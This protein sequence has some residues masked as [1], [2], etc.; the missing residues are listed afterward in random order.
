[1]TI[2]AWIR[3]RLGRDG[4][5][6]WSK[7]VGDGWQVELVDPFLEVADRCDEIR[8]GQIKEKFGTLRIYISGPKWAQDL[9]DALEI[10]SASYCED[11]G[12]KDGW[13]TADDSEAAKVTNAPV[14][15]WW[16]TLCQHCRAS[17]EESK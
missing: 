13:R 9:A 5:R 7:A 14:R 8:I 15:G 4:Y 12:R 6:P 11:C 2:L 1:M 16:R 10:A 3:K 17:R